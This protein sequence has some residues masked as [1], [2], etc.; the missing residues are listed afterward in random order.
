M[1]LKLIEHCVLTELKH[2][3]E[4]SLAT[5]HLQQIDKVTVSELLK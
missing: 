5:E 2:E 3:M 1:C 4:L